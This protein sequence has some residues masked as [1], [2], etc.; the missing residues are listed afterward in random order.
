MNAMHL[1]RG[2]DLGACG[3]RVRAEQLTASRSAVTCKSCLKQIELSERPDAPERPLKTDISPAPSSFFTRIAGVEDL[4][5]HWRV[6]CPVIWCEHRSHGRGISRAT[7][8]AAAPRALPYSAIE[9]RAP[10]ADCDPRDRHG[11]YLRHPSIP[12]I[13]PGVRAFAPRRLDNASPRRY[14]HQRLT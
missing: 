12:V 8:D 7:G 9:W 4:R 6:R 5:D 11:H 10:L 14:S 1:R 13:P 3:H 2:E